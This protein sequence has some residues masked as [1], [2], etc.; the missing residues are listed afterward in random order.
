M[1]QDDCEGRDGVSMPP[2]LGICEDVD[3]GDNDGADGCNGWNVGWSGW[4]ADWNIGGW[5]GIEEAVGGIG[6]NEIL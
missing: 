5:E 1:F 6:S 4:K 3:A 2:I